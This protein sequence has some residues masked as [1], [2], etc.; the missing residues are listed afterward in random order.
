ML[1]LMV[2]FQ[3][4]FLFLLKFVAMNLLGEGHTTQPF[5]RAMGFSTCKET[6]RN[7]GNSLD[8]SFQALGFLYS[9]KLLTCLPLS[10]I[11][12]ITS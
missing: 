7:D 12:E 5:D 8:S 1:T 10:P 2:I 11:W 4:I 3:L 6:L 9:I